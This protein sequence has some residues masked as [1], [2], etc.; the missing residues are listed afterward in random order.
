MKKNI[1]CFGFVWKCAKF[2]HD[3]N[4][5]FITQSSMKIAVKTEERGEGNF[6]HQKG[7][8]KGFIN[9]PFVF[10]VG[11]RTSYKDFLEKK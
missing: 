7:N 2:A 10:F 11:T 4:S 1:F 3:L 5:F 6:W 8:S 9:Q